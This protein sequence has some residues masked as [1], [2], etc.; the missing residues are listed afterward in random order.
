M[1][2]ASLVVLLALGTAAS[3]SAQAPKPLTVT[4]D[5]LIAP[6]EADLSP[7]GSAAVS[8][9]G[10]I[11]IGQMDDNLIKVFAPNGAIS[12]IGGKG[13]GPGE[14]QRVT[15]IGF[16]GD[17]LWALDPSLSRIN[18][19]GPDFKYVRT[20]AQPLSAMS[21]GPE[22]DVSYFT[23]AVLPGGD[24]RAIAAIRPKAAKPS[25]AVGS[26]S[27]AT[28]TVRISPNGEFKGPLLVSPPSRCR[29]NY[30]FGKGSGSWSIPFCPEHLSTDWDG[31]S[32]VAEVVVEGAAGKA[33]SYRVRVVDDRGSVRFTRS[34]PFKPISVTKAALDSMVKRRA[35]TLK[36]MP[37]VMA[38]AVPD[39]KPYPTYPPIRR[40]I[41]GRD[42]SVWLEE[43]TT[44]GGHRWLVL[45]PKGT[46]VGVVT[47][48]N[49]VSIRVA[50]LGTIWATI[51]D[52][53][54]LQGIVRYK[55]GR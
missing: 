47:L 24:I 26:D 18:I 39:P 3:A 22:Q 51:A 38:K 44:A 48:P 5:L 29:I 30:T 52:A 33:T 1:R 11:L 41:L 15:R 27:G 14:F 50:E 9:R 53:D 37:P 7:V 40:V 8:P 16:I 25:W 23:Q 28:V 49:E 35:E 54:D 20:F 43:R 17:S 2:F 31:G 21:A 42:Y 12:T 10:H 13:S 34:I 32:G 6:E 46:T 4:R 45:D 55:V 36:T 19:Y